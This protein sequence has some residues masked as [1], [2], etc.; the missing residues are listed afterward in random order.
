MIERNRGAR[1]PAANVPRAGSTVAVSRGAPELGDE[2]P[3][4]QFELVRVVQ[5]HVV[6][7]PR[8]RGP[9]AERVQRLAD[10]VA[11]VATLA[12]ASIRSCAR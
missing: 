4:G 12:S 8:E 10:Q 3:R 7:A 1:P 5:Q 6:K 9:I 2:A 11:G